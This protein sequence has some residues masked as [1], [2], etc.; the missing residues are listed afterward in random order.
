V[1]ARENQVELFHQAFCK[2][3]LKLHEAN[4]HAI[5]YPWAERVRDEEG[6]LT[7]NPMNIPTVLPLLK[8]FMHKLFL[9]TMGGVY[10]IQVL[11]GTEQDLV[12]IMETIVGG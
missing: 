10:H 11:L 1:A 5:I 6:I 12:T 9:C 3:Y 4:S 8:K 2:W 7:K